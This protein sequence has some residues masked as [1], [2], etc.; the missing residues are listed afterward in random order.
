MLSFHVHSHGTSRGTYGF[1]IKTRDL[2]RK[3]G[4]VLCFN[5]ILHVCHML[6]LKTTIS[7]N[8]NS[9]FSVAFCVDYRIQMLE[10]FGLT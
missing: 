3:I 6:S 9:G 2:N 4:H 1:T 10:D 5:M 8:V 7:T